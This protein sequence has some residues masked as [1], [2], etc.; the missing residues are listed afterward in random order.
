MT[1]SNAEV[2]TFVVPHTANLGETLDSYGNVRVNFFD[3][4][5][6]QQ[7][8]PVVEFFSSGKLG[9]LHGG[10][11]NL[12]DLRTPITAADISEMQVED[13]SAQLQAQRRPTNHFP[14]CQVS[15]TLDLRG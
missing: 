3:E 11:L 15:F 4:N 5:L 9:A 7:K 13:F 10:L 12:D 1:I 2:Y 14:K 6:E 8:A